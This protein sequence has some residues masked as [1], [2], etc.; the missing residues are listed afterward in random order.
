MSREA[1][2]A[3]PVEAPPVRL[4]TLGRA[5]ISLPPAAAGRPAPRVQPPA[6]PR[7]PAPVCEVDRSDW[8]LLVKLP[9]V[10]ALV[11]AGELQVA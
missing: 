5:T 7:K 6:D 10:A 1:A 9:Q 11:A 2:P 3:A 4:S 8:D